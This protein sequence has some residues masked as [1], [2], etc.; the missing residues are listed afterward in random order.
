M[1]GDRGF[2]LIEILVALF[3]AALIFIAIPSSD[4]SRRHQDLQQ[5]VEDIDRSVRFAGSEAVLRNVIVRLRF[6]LAKFPV[7]FVVE[8]GPKDDL[9]LPLPREQ[10]SLSIEEAEKE[11]KRAGQLD[12]QF[13][14]V[15]EF[16]DITREL[17][18]EVEL[19]GVATQAQ[20]ALQRDGMVSLYFYPTGERDAAI[21]FFATQDEI[22]SLEIEPFQEKT[23]AEYV[24]LP[25]QG[26]D[27]AKAGDFRDTKV[28]ELTKNWLD[29]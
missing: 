23:R 11:K 25:R 6:N 27:V 4:E 9:V 15:E 2:S 13:T 18:G 17:P 12:A 5:A 22:A 19:L 14:R 10:K 20:K 21:V 1:R 8:Y 16:A 28:E 29:K 24:A 7:E 26:P 3:L